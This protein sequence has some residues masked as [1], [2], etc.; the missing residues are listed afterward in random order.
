MKT[1]QE[2]IEVAIKN[3][4]HIIPRETKIDNYQFSELIEANYS[5]SNP[6]TQ[7]IWRTVRNSTNLRFNRGITGYINVSR[8][9]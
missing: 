9:R 4:G 2:I 3:F 8:I 5:V 6:L 1:E 7:A